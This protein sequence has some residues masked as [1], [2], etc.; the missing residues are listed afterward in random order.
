MITAIHI[1]FFGALGCVARYYLSGRAYALLGIGWPYGTL[2]VNALGSFLIGIVMEAG[3]RGAPMSPSLRLG[4]TAGFLGGF[5]TFSAFS[6]E[7]VRMIG[8]GR[9]LPA[10]ANVG[11]NVAA[12]LLATALGLLAARQI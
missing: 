7:T 8:E 2:V 12:C 11:A 5:T 3:I 9:I 6:Y 1:A 4:L 10:M